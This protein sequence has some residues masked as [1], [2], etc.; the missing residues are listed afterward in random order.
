MKTTGFQMMDRMEALREQGEI[1]N[2]QFVRSLFRF[3]TEQDKPHPRDLMQTYADCEGKLPC[4]KQRRR[5]TM[6]WFRCW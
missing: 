1:A 5:N 3:T 2:K 6:C 4:C